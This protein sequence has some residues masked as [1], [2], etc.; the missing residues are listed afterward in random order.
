MDFVRVGVGIGPRPD[1]RR[2]D[3][4]ARFVLRRMDARERDKVEGLAGAVWRELEKRR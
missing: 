1:S 2:S 4:V 3:D